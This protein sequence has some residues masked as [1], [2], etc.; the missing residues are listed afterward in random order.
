M[1][2]APEFFQKEVR[3][4][5]EIPEMMKRAWAAELEVLEVVVDICERN[6]LQYFADWGTLLGA[7]RHQGFIPWDDD[8]DICLKREEYM[9][10]IRI[11][12]E[13]LPKGF[14]LAGLYADSE[15]L[16][17]HA[18]WT[19]SSVIADDNGYWGIQELMKRFHGFP[20]S[21]F[22]IDIFPL[23]YL[24]TD[25]ELFN[26]QK[27][28]V[29]YGVSILQNWDICVNNGE[30]EK[31]LAYMEELCGMS[32]PRD[33]STMPV[34][35]RR[36]DAIIALYQENEAEE[37]SESP[38]YLD[39]ESY[40]MKKEWYDRAVKLPF[41]NIEIAVPCG[42]HEVLTAQYGDYKKPVRGLQAHTYPFY[43]P[44]ERELLRQLRENGFS[45]TVD[46][47]CHNVLHGEFKVKML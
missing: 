21:G 18:Q 8:M 42:Y 31:R 26:A 34:L 40:H 37:M 12:P 25:T 33:N 23:D 46:E 4:G 47:F 13:Q 7:V 6:G 28:I 19:H 17:N 36:L 9:E 45:G 41:E 2:F 20:Y 10:L 16:R 30:L 38:F 29:A 43:A 27:L 35:R 11:L 24:P 32:L 15:R 3:C 39:N 44:K 5:F 1:E 14:A 22:G